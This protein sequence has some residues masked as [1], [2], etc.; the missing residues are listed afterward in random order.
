VNSD[1]KEFYESGAPRNFFSG[2]TLAYLLK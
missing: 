2:I 1:R